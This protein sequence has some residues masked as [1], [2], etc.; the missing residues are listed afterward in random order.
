MAQGTRNTSLC[1][2]ST[3]MSKS[4]SLDVH[5]VLEVSSGSRCNPQEQGPLAS[6]RHCYCVHLDAL[7]RCIK[8]GH[9]AEAC[10]Q[11]RACV[12]AQP[13]WHQLRGRAVKLQASLLRARLKHRL[14]GGGGGGIGTANGSSSFAASSEWWRCSQSTTAARVCCCTHDS[15]HKGPR[16]HHIP[17]PPLLPG[18]TPGSPHF[19]G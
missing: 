9:V 5:F 13:A 4:S 7:P 6:S 10:R 16:K 18:N 8:S 19:A 2:T 3:A 17:A 1:V 12:G 15:D 14:E 11:T